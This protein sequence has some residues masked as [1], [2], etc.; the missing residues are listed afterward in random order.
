MTSIRNWPPRAL[1]ALA[2]SASTGLHSLHTPW[3][4]APSAVRDWSG[5]Q[6]GAPA[7]PAPLEIL[8]ESGNYLR[9]TPLGA[10]LSDFSIRRLSS[11]PGLNSG[12]TFAST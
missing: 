12:T 1:F 9:V 10:A 11:F 5:K 6:R 3:S 8:S 2:S 7:S 4:S